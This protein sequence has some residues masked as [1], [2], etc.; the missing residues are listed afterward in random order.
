[1]RYHCALSQTLRVLTVISK[2]NNSEYAIS[3]L[4][5][6]TSVL[7]LA[8]LWEFP[9]VR[10]H[11]IKKLSKLDMSP[12]HKISIARQFHVP[13]WE[14]PA[15][16]QLVQRPEPMNMDDV[17]S[18]GIDTVLKLSALRESLV[19]VQSIS[20]YG[21][22]TSTRSQMREGLRPTSTIDFTPKLR[23]LFRA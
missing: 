3:T 11:A 23:Q 17:Q 16:N 9:R 10:E 20:T 14:L 8:S 5:D 1:V 4:E 13:G 2:L 22:L 7:R 19:E 18:L 21:I 15:L 6:W 12:T